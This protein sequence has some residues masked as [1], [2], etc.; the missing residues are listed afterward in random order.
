LVRQ[1][2]RATADT[3]SVVVD[4]EA[5]YFGVKVN[6][7]SLTPALGARLGKTRFQDWLKRTAKAA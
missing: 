2:L 5:L 7:Q 1:F 4:P 6:D 3:R